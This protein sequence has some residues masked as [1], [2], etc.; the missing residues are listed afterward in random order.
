MAVTL[1]KAWV[2]SVVLTMTASISF[3]SS[4]FAPVDVRLGP[5]M[6]LGGLGQV[7]LVHVAQ[8]DDVLARHG[9]HVFCPAAV[10]PDDA[11]VQF[12]VGRA[13]LGRGPTARQ[14]NA[15]PS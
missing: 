10:H 3:W 9:P 7:V 14:P 5:R 6:A 12:F 4:I 8:G 2:C 15:R 13:A 1:A 11:E